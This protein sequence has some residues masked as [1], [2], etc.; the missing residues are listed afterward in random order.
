MSE[1]KNLEE[2]AQ[3]LQEQILEQ[4]RKEYSEQKAQEVDEE[5]TRILGETYG[6]ARQLLEEHRE[7]LDVVG[8]ALLERETLEGAELQLL[9]EG[10]TLPPLPVPIVAEERQTKDASPKRTEAETAEFPGKKLPDP[11]PVPG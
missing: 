7:L 6:K 10:E 1:Q 4:A 8:D 2:F 11:E 5:I 9:I 3:A